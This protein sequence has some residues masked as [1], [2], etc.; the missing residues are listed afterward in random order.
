MK[1]Q[2]LPYIIILLFSS[3]LFACPSPKKYPDE[4]QVEFLEVV[5]SDGLDQLQNPVKNCKFRFNLIDGDGDFGLNPEDSIGVDIDTVFRNNFL[6]IFYEVK[7][8]DTLQLD[9]LYGYC[10]RIPDLRQDGQVK[11]IQATV[12]IDMRFNYYNDTL[13]YDTVLFEFFVID[14]ALNKSNVELTP[15]IKLDTI[16]KFP[17]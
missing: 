17:K 8:S 7:N 10:F 12:E 5:L 14:R 16:G 6:S 1:H 9:S 2:L 11:T 15:L 3:I 4:P 13:N